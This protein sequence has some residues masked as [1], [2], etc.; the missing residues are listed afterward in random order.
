MEVASQGRVGPQ[1]GGE[2][3]VYDTSQFY[4]KMYD[5]Q[6]DLLAQREKKKKE[7]EQQQKAWNSLLEDMPDVWQADQEHVRQAVDK[8]ND[9]IVDLKAQGIDPDTLDSTLLRKMKGLEN[10]IRKAASVAK[11]NETYYNNSFQTLNQDKAN[12][13]NKIH[14]TDWLKQYSDPNKTPQERAKMRV[15]SNP[16]KINYDL[17]EFT[18]N[19]IPDKEVI[20]GKDK[21]TT[22]RNKDAHRGIVL[23]YIMNDPQGQ[24]V[25]ESLKK[26]NESE[27][28]FAERVAQKGQE[29]F[30]INEEPI[31]KST[32]RSSSSGTKTKK[33]TIREKSLDTTVDPATNQPV[34]DQSRPHNKV[35]LDNTPPVYVT[36]DDNTR[37]ADFVPVGGFKIKPNGDIIAV[38]EGKSEEDS[39]V[40]EVEINYKKNKDQ[41]NIKGY[42]DME[43][44]F[45][46]SGSGKSINRSQVAEK[47]KA[48]GYTNVSEYESILKKNGVTINEGK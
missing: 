4:N 39:S 28:D 1:G 12:K 29:L 37:I 44:A 43:S 16:F 19:T 18:K 45:S 11:D 3:T 26:P 32:P 46:G 36:K 6:K 34:Y 14:A 24:D 23:D 47:A 10:D 9:F 5:L 25:Y 48:A 35:L 27:A 21:K 7:Y 2:A 41:F 33:P 30:P 22:Q 17:I 20:V 31:K 42:P 38:G 15:E 8:Y 40:V 13:Y